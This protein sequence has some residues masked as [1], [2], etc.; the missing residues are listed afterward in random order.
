VSGA[1]IA[2]NAFDDPQ[3]RAEADELWNSIDWSAAVIS[4][5]PSLPRF[6]L[7]GTQIDGKEKGTITMFNEY[8]LLA[9]FCQHYENRKKGEKA[10]RHIMPD[11][12][13]LPVAVYMNRILLGS[14]RGGL[15]PSFLVQ[16]PFYMSDLCSDELYFSYTA[17]QAEADRATNID[18]N[19]DRSAWGVGPGCT[20]EKGYS[21]NSFLRNPENVVSPRIVAGFIAVHPP[22]ATDLLLRHG[23]PV[24]RLKLEFGTILPRFVP[25]KDWKPYR[26]AG[27]DF[28][29][30]LLGMA[31]HHPKVGIEFFQKNTKFTFNE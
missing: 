24:N 8:I 23:D 22:A 20:P 14:L 27:I 17:A 18:R 31:G 29:C 3:I 10:R 13:K 25:G 7:K 1:L 6:Y 9:W 2:R 15:Q 4:T 11:L 21:V 19:K 30:L 5:D 12:D 26:L 16:F 28:G